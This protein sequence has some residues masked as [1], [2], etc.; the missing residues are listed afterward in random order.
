MSKLNYLAKVLA[1][2]ILQSYQNYALC[3]TYR[4]PLFHSRPMEW[5]EE[6][7]V[8]F[9][10]EMVA[11][12]VF[13]TKKGSPAPGLAWEAIV[14][15]LNE[16][17]SPKFQLKDKKAVRER[18]NLLR[19]TFSKKMSEEEKA[20]GISVEELTEKESL[21]EELVDR[22]DTIHAKAESASK[23]QL[24]DNETA[25]DIRKKAMERLKETKKRNSDEGG[26]S[27]KRRKS[28]RAEPLVDFLREKA[29]ALRVKQQ[30][31]ESQQQMIKN[32]ILQ[33]QEMNNAF[34]TVVKKLLD[35]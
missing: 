12:N 10:R 3:F 1:A 32:M 31:Q 18:W 22:E 17:H 9:L 7:D 24:K 35:K 11:R 13:G 29:A 15:S 14:D 26:A 20:S 23:Q 16:I 34:L 8:L 28:R 2:L 30:E 4:F 27:P 25:E 5:S 6:H 33:Q 21:I 19:E